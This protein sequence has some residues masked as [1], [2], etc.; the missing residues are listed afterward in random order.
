[1]WLIPGLVCM[2][3]GVLFTLPFFACLGAKIINIFIKIVLFVTSFHCTKCKKRN[4]CG[5]TLIITL[6]EI[7]S[8]NNESFDIAHCTC[9]GNDFIKHFKHCGEKCHTTI[10]KS[11]LSGYSPYTYTKREISGYNTVRKSRVNKVFAGCETRRICV[12]EGYWAHL[13][14][15][16]KEA[17][18]VTEY[19]TR[20]YMEPVYEDRQIPVYK[21]VIEY[22]DENAP[23]YETRTYTENRPAYKDIH[24][25]C[26][27]LKCNCAKCSKAEFNCTCNCRYCLRNNYIITSKITR[28]FVNSLVIGVIIIIIGVAIALFGEK[29]YDIFGINII[30]I[31]I[32]IGGLT[33]PPLFC[34]LLCYCVRKI[35][36]S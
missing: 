29:I 18:D 36:N 2:G 21:D 32:I 17:R 22:Y 1:M 34:M 27:C 13:N 14:R 9:S 33:V 19:Y 16:W 10:K 15:D 6:D 31:A 3:I 20:R 35:D 8:S 7:I 24:E 12:K 30:I 5:N 25:L 11:I 4:H 26:S 23:I 28:P